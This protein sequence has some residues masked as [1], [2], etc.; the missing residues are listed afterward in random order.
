MSA[1]RIDVLGPL[2]VHD[3]SGAPITVG[4]PR[5]R[6][7]L[8]LLALQPGR[9]V[10][11]EQLVDGQYG[12][13]PPADAVGALQAQVAR[14]RRVL[15]AGLLVLDGGGYRLAVDPADV[16]VTTFERLAAQGRTLLAARGPEGRG[17]GPAGSSAR[18][19]GAVGGRRPTR[20]GPGARA[21]RVRRA[22]PQAW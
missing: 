3:G 12:G 1:L 10:P 13:D 18:S 5:P 8:V 6:A 14:L 4:G 11:V 17:R 9:T 21:T 16:D 15:P 19:A 7:L 20:L 2:Q 22:G